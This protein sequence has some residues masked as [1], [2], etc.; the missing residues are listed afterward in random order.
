MSDP[1]VAT[2]DELQSPVAGASGSKRR[3]LGFD[4]WTEGSH[5]FERLVPAF[6]R[7][8]LELLLIHIGSW[9][10]D[11]GRPAEEFIGRLKVRDISYYHGAGFEQIL[12]AERP[13][14][15]LF[16]STRA[17]AHQA[18]NRYAA[19]LKIPTVHLLHGLMSV[20]AVGVDSSKTYAV[21]YWQLLSAW[22][23][24]IGKNLFKL[25][26]LYMRAL[27]ETR[28]PLR[29]WAGLG[30]ELV[31]KALARNNNS[32]LAPV[33]AA[34]TAGCVYTRADIPFLRDG[35]RVAEPAI[36]VVGNPDLA[37]FGLVAED[38]GCGLETASESATEVMYIDTALI[39]AG[40]VFDSRGDFINHLRCSHEKLAA[41]GFRMVVKLHPAHFRTG[42]PEALDAL[43]IPICSGEDFVARL[44]TAAAVIVEPTTA[45]MIPA[46]MGK[47]LFLAQYGKFTGQRYGLAL[48][49]YPRASALVELEQFAALL[50][51]IRSRRCAEELR[52]WTAE[53]AGPL[54]VEEMPKRVADALANVM[55]QG[56]QT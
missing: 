44:R 23:D 5:H 25:I 28:A 9:G 32:I 43:Q 35:Y 29:D 40:V 27:I 7:Q 16:L 14:A 13:S 31:N 41:Q 18:F 11:K 26:P 20:Q 24:K 49:T 2:E 48:T 34:T 6:E 1:T 33:D 38:F 4:S 3:V 56:A 54:P 17:F 37:R 8:G 53:N 52:N 42:V 51:A 21:N 45:A 22:S 46:L 50:A 10:H 12:S 30:V 15:V 19:K 36:Y 55:R 39:E 47:P